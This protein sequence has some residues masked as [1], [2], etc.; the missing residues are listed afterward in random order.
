MMAFMAVAGISVFFA[1]GSDAHKDVRK[2][3]RERAAARRAQ[4]KT[5]AAQP[6]PLALS[7]PTTVSAPLKLRLKPGAQGRTSP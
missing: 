2:E 5:A 3:L 4:R 6:A 7:A 1:L